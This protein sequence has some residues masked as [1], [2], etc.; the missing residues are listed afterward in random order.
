[1]RWLITHNRRARL[2]AVVGGAR[3]PVPDLLA[4]ELALRVFHAGERI[5]DQDDVAAAAEHRAANADRVVE[6]A[7]LGVPLAAGLAVLGELGVEHGAI[8]AAG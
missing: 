1:M 7:G 8:F 2:Q 4:L 3:V 6:A 5:V